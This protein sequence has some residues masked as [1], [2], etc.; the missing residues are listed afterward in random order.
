M[1]LR[2]PTSAATSPLSRLRRVAPP[3][4][5]PIQASPSLSRLSSY[6][7]AMLICNMRLP[8]GDVLVESTGIGLVGELVA[9]F[10]VTEH[11]RELGKD[12]QV[13]LGRL[14]GYE[15]QKDQI[16]R[17]SVRSI[18]CHGPCEADERSD[19][20]LQALDP[21]VGNG[22]PMAEAGRAEALA[23]EQAVENE[24]PRDALVV[25]DNQSR[26]L[27]H[28][29]LA[30]HVQIQEDVGGRKKFGDQIHLDRA[31]RC[32]AALRHAQSM[33][34]CPK[35]RGI[36]HQG[37]DHGGVRGAPDPHSDL[38]MLTEGICSDSRYFAMV[39]RAT[40]IPCCPR[41]SEILLSER[42]FLASSAAT[43]CL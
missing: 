29:L 28:A 4:L 16:H 34:G 36:L 26:L 22:D 43:S 10:P 30:R 20:L 3:A 14:F 39:R 5:P 38:R 7:C 41:I 8:C 35:K 24:T 18:E 27:E 11:L 33:P 31:D 32:M 17:V 13:Q 6:S 19:G 15:K 9:Q 42:G 21:A 12:A 37:R 1:R 23:R 2:S 25:L 40:T